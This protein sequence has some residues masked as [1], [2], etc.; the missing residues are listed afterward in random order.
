MSRN[1]P[2][3]LSSAGLAE[4][5]V[6]W[7]HTH[8]QR[9]ERAVDNT[10]QKRR[11]AC[12]AK[13]ALSP[14]P[15]RRRSGRVGGAAGWVRAWGG[16]RVCRGRVA[17]VSGRV[18][19]ACGGCVGGV[20][21]GCVGVC[22]RAVSACV[23]DADCAVR[24]GARD[25]PPPLRPCV[26]SF[27][28]SASCLWPLF[29][30]CPQGPALP[31]PGNF[32]FSP[33]NETDTDTRLVCDVRRARR[34]YSPSPSSAT[35]VPTAPHA[36]IRRRRP[37]PRLPPPSPALGSSRLG[38]PPGGTSSFSRLDCLQL[39]LLS[40]R[41]PSP[42]HVAFIRRPHTQLQISPPRRKHPPAPRGPSTRP[43]MDVGRPPRCVRAQEAAVRSG[44]AALRPCPGGFPR[45]PRLR[46]AKAA[47]ASAALVAAYK[48]RL[49]VGHATRATE[50]SAC[51]NGVVA[52]AG[53]LAI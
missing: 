25:S 19:G 18:A 30:V 14:V 26:C 33:G 35:A 53:L 31:S 34:F 10:P 44:A 51:V 20:C 41:R 22:W 37:R 27:L 2:S 47:P 12:G 48:S 4:R 16:C 29:C 11:S 24:P 39:P 38:R 28:F 3:A 42:P 17:G 9:A 1:T 7:S 43:G 6:L 45:P 36:T 15:H 40:A 8:R 52:D 50:A 46:G 49:R 13:K 23:L 5:Q 32:L 21:Q